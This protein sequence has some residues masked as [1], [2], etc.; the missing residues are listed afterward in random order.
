V[1]YQFTANAP[2]ANSCFCSYAGDG[3]MHAI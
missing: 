1:L 3:G 2:N